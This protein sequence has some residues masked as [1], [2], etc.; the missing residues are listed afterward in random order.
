MTTCQLHADNA[1]SEARTKLE[2][3][4]GDVDELTRQSKLGC[5]ISLPCMLKKGGDYP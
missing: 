5:R 4:Y 2:Y 3:V 1:I